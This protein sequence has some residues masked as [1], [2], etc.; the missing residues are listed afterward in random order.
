MVKKQV[1]VLVL[2]SNETITLDSPDRENGLGVID[3]GGVT[4]NQGKV[5]L[6]ASTEMLER[7]FRSRRTIDAEDEIII[8]R[9]VD[10]Q[11]HL[12]F[13]GTCDAIFKCR[14]ER[15]SYMDV[16]RNDGGIMVTL[17]R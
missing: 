14:I 15:L 7:K 1:D 10:P 5:I 4:I 13:E 11:T 8:H 12:T 6:A 3:N 16:L 9:F 2:N 17:N